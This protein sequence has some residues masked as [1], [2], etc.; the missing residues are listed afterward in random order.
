M[1]PELGLFALVLA[2][3]VAG[4]QAV[5]PLA[6]AHWGVVGWAPGAARHAAGR[7]VPVG[8]LPVLV[9]LAGRLLGAV[10]GG[11]SHSALPMAYKLA[12]FWGG[13]EGS[14][15]LWQLLLAC[16]TWRWPGAA[17]TCP[18]LRGA[19]AGG[20]GLDQR[21][22]A[23]V[24]AVSLQPVYA[25]D[26][27]A[28]EGK[29]LN[30]LLQD[31]GMV[32]HPPL[33][34]MGYVGFAV[35]FAFALAALISGELGAAWARWSRSWTLAAWGFLTLGILL[36]SAWAYYVLGWGG[37]WFWDPVENAS[38]M[39]W[40][41]GTAL[42]HSLIVTDQRGAFRSWSALLAICAFSLSLLGTF[43]VRSGVLT[44]VHAFAVDPGAGSS[45]CAS[46]WPWWGF[47]V[48]V[49]LAGPALGLKAGSPCSRASRCC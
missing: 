44:S 36:G 20:A 12:A 21:G 32:L 28:P 41:V 23:A 31:P 29:D 1:I 35:P 18:G 6:G 34:Y 42:L 3:I 19:R 43:L 40:L 38:F 4:V 33:L 48:A 46:S 47:A 5:V 2:L 25:P 22:P 24:S 15:L 8:R 14:M 13:H 9:L 27:G 7:A 30:P 16:W 49:C 37:W 11:N 39:P 26:A 17:A 10:C 45:S